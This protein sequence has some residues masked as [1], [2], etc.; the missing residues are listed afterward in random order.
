M[1]I[2]LTGTS[3]TLAQQLVNLFPN[4]YEI[5]SVSSHTPKFEKKIIHLCYSSILESGYDVDFIIHAGFPRNNCV[6][7]LRE[8]LS[9]NKHFANWSLKHCCGGFINISTQSVYGEKR[10]FIVDERSPLRLDNPYSVVKHKSEELFSHTLGEKI[11][12]TNIRLGSLIGPSYKQR[13]VYKLTQQATKNQKIRIA[14][15]GFIFSYLDVRDAAFAILKLLGRENSWES[16]FNV[17]S[18]S[19][20]TISE[21]C[22]EIIRATESNSSLEISKKSENSKKEFVNTIDSSLFKNKFNWKENFSLT[23]SIKTIKENLDG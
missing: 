9:F 13:F 11:P 17:G 10:L 8:F 3:G 22:S 20:Y 23:E 2:L 14:E 4:D 6:K 5:I 19:S 18:N 21:I 15:N 1:R 16:I 12:I 7:Q